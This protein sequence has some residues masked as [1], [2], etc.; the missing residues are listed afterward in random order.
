MKTL[1]INVLIVEDSPV[2]QLLLAHVLEADSQLRVMGTVASGEAALEFLHRETPDVILMDVHLPKVDGFETTRRIMETHPVPIVIC[3]G[4]SDPTEVSATFRALEAGAL[5][6]VAKPVGPADPN[7]E[8]VSKNL[9]QTV[10]LMS[11]IRVVRRWGRSCQEGSAAGTGPTQEPERR[12]PDPAD[13]RGR[14]AP[15]R[16]S[17]LRS[18]AH[19]PEACAEPG[20]PI[21]ESGT[22]GWASQAPPAFSPK[23]IIASQNSDHTVSDVSDRS[24]EKNQGRGGTHPDQTQTPLQLVAIGAS[25]GGPAVLQMILSGLAA[26]FPLPILVVQH[27]AAGFLSGLMEWLQPSCRLPIRAATHAEQPLA[28][29]VYFAPDSQEMG[30]DGSGRITLAKDKGNES[31]CPS[32]GHLFRSVT[33]ACGGS[34]VGVLLTGM[35]KDGA[36]ELKR[37]RDRGGITIAQDEATSIVHG[38]PGEAIRLGAATF[39]LPPEQIATTLTRLAKA[40]AAKPTV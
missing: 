15:D 24:E 33:A 28:G 37:L 4:T 40:G 21:H 6:F 29:V 22:D 10:K 3:S 31:V 38:M 17:A 2:L 7:F 12:S 5:A 1:P 26:D 13:S 11:E 36:E 32:V 39:V 23:R 34:A 35:G 25:T 14:F 18:P 30:V 27:I 16:R 20:E 19:G 8:G 9:T